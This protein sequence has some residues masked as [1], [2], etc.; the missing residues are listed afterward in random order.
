MWRLPC[1]LDTS[2]L[3]DGGE[4]NNQADAEFA[5]FVARVRKDA[6]VRQD[7]T[8]HPNGVD[9]REWEK[10]QGSVPSTE[11]SAVNDSDD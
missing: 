4:M 5:D 2:T 6:E 8:E 10:L 1:E 9:P 3:S 7:G 11:G